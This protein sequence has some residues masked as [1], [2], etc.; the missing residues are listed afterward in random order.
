MAYYV[1]L[2][3][4][5][6][7]TVALIQNI[8]IE[9]QRAKNRHK[10]RSAVYFAIAIGNVLVSIPLIKAYGAVG[11]A[12]GTAISYIPGSIFFMNI[13]YHR[14]LRLDIP[15]FWRQIGRI[16]VAVAPAFGLGIAL[17]LLI[18]IGNWIEMVLLILVYS[19]LYCAC[20]YLWGMNK[21]EKELV[22]VMLDKIGIRKK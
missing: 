18:D 4:M 21:E 3:L 6:P 22:G 10:I 8:G 11:A 12:A 9:I 19:A 2:F 17:W 5:V 13:Y 16:I 1:G 7:V 15:E 20:A 14:V